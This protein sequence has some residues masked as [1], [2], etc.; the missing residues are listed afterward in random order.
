MPS[1]FVA[2]I[3][4]VHPLHVESV[5]W[6]SSRKDMLT[7]FFALPALW[8]YAKHAEQ[9]KQPGLRASLTSTNHWI[10]L[11]FFGAALLS[12]PMLVSLPAVMLLLDF[13]PL[14][15]ISTQS[16]PV[17]FATWRGLLTEKI[18][19]TL[20][21]VGLALT[22]FFVHEKSGAIRSLSEISITD[23]IGGAFVSYARYIGK[24]VW[25]ADLALPYPIVEHWPTTISLLATFAIIAASLAVLARSRQSPWLVTGW[26]MFL[27]ELFPVIGIEQWG[28]QSFADRYMYVPLIGLSIIVAWSIEHLERAFSLT[29]V[30]IAFRVLIISTLVWFTSAQLNHWPNSISLFT[31]S[32]AVTKDNAVA[33]IC[34]GSAYEQQNRLDDAE[35]ELREALR[36]RPRHQDALVNL[37]VVLR[38]KGDL[39]AAQECFNT[40]LQLGGNATAHFYLALILVKSGEF[41]SAKENYL[42]AIALKPGLVEAH[43]NLG[44]I[45][46]DQRQLTNAAASF[47]QALRLHPAHSQARLNLA[48]ARFEMALESLARNNPEDSITHLRDATRLAPDWIDPLNGLAWLLATLPKDSMR[49][50]NEALLL[51]ERAASLSN[52]TNA[53][54]LDTLSAAMAESG[55]FDEALS[56]AQAALKIAADRSLRQTNRLTLHIES[57]SQGKP[58]RE[59]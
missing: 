51:A 26:I 21:A 56:T 9:I 27:A 13:W 34:L 45:W 42:K 54:V 41:E 18:P 8:F 49:N 46:L 23:R 29:R 10:A 55:R 59:Q 7:T 36:I 4:A 1:A 17:S 40:A 39:A 47:I 38:R 31:H 53:F 30:A 35:R 37:G 52:H 33:H 5:A 16:K 48:R 44:V 20:L 32:I 43:N 25:P 11:V 6:V 50:G 58:W 2:V 12:K 24:A 15:R 19:F 57:Y 14:N 3:F 28:A 22:A